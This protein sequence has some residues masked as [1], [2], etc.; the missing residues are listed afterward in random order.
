R[1]RRE[2][3]EAEQQLHLAEQRRREA[4][5]LHEKADRLDPDAPRDAVVDPPQ[6]ARLDER[7]DPV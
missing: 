5:D 1:A 7:G 4:L 6:T 3:V 2:Q